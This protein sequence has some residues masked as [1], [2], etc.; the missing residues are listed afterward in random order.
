MR[1]Q[2]VRTELGTKKDRLTEQ[3]SATSKCNIMFVILRLV[4]LTQAA[5]HMATM[6]IRW[7]V[8]MNAGMLHILI[9]LL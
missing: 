9:G 1:L 8:T 2:R 5:L 7:H 6:H 4:A 3:N